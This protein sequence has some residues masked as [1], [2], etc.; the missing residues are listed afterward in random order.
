[1]KHGKK[2]VPRDKIIVKDPKVKIPYSLYNKIYRVARDEE[3]STK[4]MIYHMLETFLELR[5][6]LGTL[7]VYMEDTERSFQ[8]TWTNIESQE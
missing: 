6:E 2:I 4:E 5:K 1:M 3:T 7:S 8:G